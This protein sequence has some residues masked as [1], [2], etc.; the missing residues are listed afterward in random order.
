M[1]NIT[2]ILEKY[3][4]FKDAQIRSAQ[5]FEDGSKMVEIVV[6]DDDGQDV[7]SVEFTFENIK[8]FRILQNSVLAFIDMM[9][10]VSVIKENG[11]YGFALGSGT[12]MLHVL[13]APMYIVASEI[14]VK[15]NEN[16]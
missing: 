1:E 16:L 6:L 8:E 2:P 7:S 10:G 9:S 13:N 11:F 12:A 14:S 15:E 4:Y 3:N 5:Q